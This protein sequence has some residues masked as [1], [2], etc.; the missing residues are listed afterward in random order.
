MKKD[1]LI[2]EDPRIKKEI[3]RRFKELI[4]RAQKKTK[5]REIILRVDLDIIHA[6]KEESHSIMFMVEWNK[7]YDELLKEKIQT[8]EKLRRTT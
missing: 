5:K 1:K 3:K 4:N 2:L 6:I 8:A 7:R